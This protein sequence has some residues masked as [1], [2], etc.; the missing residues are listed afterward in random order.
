MTEPRIASADTAGAVLDRAPVEAMVHRSSGGWQR[1]VWVLPVCGF[2]LLVA[3]LGGIIAMS[4]RIGEA[5]A[6]VAHTLETRH[7]S[8]VLFSVLQDAE[9]SVRAY[10]L[11][12]DPAMVARYEAA[13]AAVPAAEDRLRALTRDNSAQANRLDALAPLITRR[14]GVLTTTVA[15]ARSGDRQAM[16]AAMRRRDGTRLMGDIRTDLAAFDTAEADLLDA[17]EQTARHDRTQL[18]LGSG[19]AL[20]LALLL[21][22]FTAILSQRQAHALRTANA[23][24]AG[25]V[26]DRTGALRDSETRFRHV[27]R[28]SPIGLT[29]SAAETRRIV[30]ANPAVCRMLG[31]TEAELV[32]RTSHDLAH[33][34]DADIMVPVS[35]DPAAAW[36]TTEKR[37]ITRSGSIVFART[38]VVP[39][40]LLDGGE[41]LTLGTIEDVTHETVIEAALRD[42]EERMRLAVEAVGLGVYEHDGRRRAVRFD[43]RA[44]ALIGGTLP[45]DAWLHFDG[46]ELTAWHGLVHPDD[47]VARKAAEDSLLHG[48]SDM[49]T[50]D[51]RVRL[52]AGGWAWL[53]T[54]GTVAERD[55]ETSRPLRVLTVVQDVTQRKETE[56]ALRHAHGLEAMGQLTGGVAHDFNNLLGAILGHTE[57]LL[58]L[59][60]EH[61]E[62]RDL[63]TEILDCALSGAALTQRLLAFARRQ[64]LQPAVI[65]LNEY[66]PVHVSL[67]QRTLGE[68]VT[69]AVALA[70]ELWLTLADP[71]QIV[72]VLL[73]LAI[74]ARDAMPHGGKLTIETMNAVLDA[75]YCA[76]HS[77]AIP[78]EYVLLSVSDTG[79][80]MTADVLARALEPFFTTKPPGKGSGLGLSTIYG[81]AR[82]SGGHLRIDS[83]PGKGAT[84]RLYLPRTM[85]DRTA[86]QA[87]KFLVPPL[88]RGYEAILVV[89]DNDN[90]RATAARNLAALGYRVRLASDGPA[91]LAILQANERFDL[92]FTD[93]VMPNGLSGFQL[94]EAARALQPGLPVLFT[95]G[96][97]ADDDGETGVLDAG[98]LRKPYRRRD[99][100]ERV[101][102]MLDG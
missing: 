41:A 12:D 99:L 28:D 46:P 19:G 67:L 8:G 40:T 69:V 102:A 3:A 66:L 17:R 68:T 32:G 85:A 81:F 6:W 51:Y 65:D 63:A 27:F 57:F 36:R 76:H 73:N 70:P 74:N 87:R 95:T 101:R 71:S 64:P 10:L 77:D 26:I 22:G 5:D 48:S 2:A 79:T 82:Q 84:V 37:Y 52:E 91:A 93:L 62:A 33:P 54:F 31:Y 39:L 59:L 58:D 94:A 90:M 92:L 14:L 38:G 60:V 9:A 18:L 61:T 15:I 43:A 72:D 88:P 89:D 21:G 44:T 47:A 1:H 78:G 34:D 98:A 23:K 100:A 96:F 25:T 86:A 80:G 30:A 35:D 45:A 13:R 75:A 50:N 16:A 55:S 83:E 4:L 56:I 11:I 97:A 7:A 24:L 29:I 49:A 20:S 53:S 42:S